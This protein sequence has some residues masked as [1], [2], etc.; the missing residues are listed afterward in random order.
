MIKIYQLIIKNHKIVF[1]KMKSIVAIH[2]SECQFIH[3]SKLDSCLAYNNDYSLTGYLY[4]LQ[5]F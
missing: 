1:N 5:K 4:Y 2:F 3:P